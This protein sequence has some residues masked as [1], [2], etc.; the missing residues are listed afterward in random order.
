MADNIEIQ[1]KALVQGLADVRALVSEI[2]KLPG[3]GAGAGADNLSKEF[4][5]VKRE[6]AAATSEIRS[7]GTAA[8]NNLKQVGAGTTVA[9]KGLRDTSRA[10]RDTKEN[11][12]ELSQGAAAVG[13][14]ITDA[15]QGNILGAM[16]SVGVALRTSFNFRQVA[17]AAVPAL[18]TIDNKLLNTA[19]L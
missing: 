7:L 17:D 19:K 15:F 16:Q 9:V 2:Q 10:S 3:A 13:R 4:A 18:T 1:I 12:A 11:L 6:V 5:E 14:A 8:Q